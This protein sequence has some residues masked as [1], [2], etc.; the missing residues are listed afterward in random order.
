MFTKKIAI[1]V[2][3]I[4]ASCKS[5]SN[6]YQGFAFYNNKP[7]SNVVIKEENAT[8]KSVK[9]DNKGYFKLIKDPCC[10][11]KLIFIKE[12]FKTDTI[13]TIYPQNGERIQYR[14]LNKKNDTLFLKP[15]TK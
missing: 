1:V 7:V 9:T 15:I 8:A 13:R 6:F 5:K 11:S 3:L 12:G 4:F 14:F 10:I 2:L